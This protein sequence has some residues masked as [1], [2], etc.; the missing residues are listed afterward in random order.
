MAFR[1]TGFSITNP[2]SPEN[3]LS[4]SERI[5]IAF[6]VVLVALFVIVMGLYFVRRH[7]RY[8]N[9]APRNSKTSAIT[10][11]SQLTKCHTRDERDNLGIDMQVL[12]EQTKT[13]G[14]PGFNRQEGNQQHHHDDDD[15]DDDGLQLLTS[16]KEGGG[17]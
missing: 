16:S 17:G 13:A 5:A 1:C 15:D 8:R 3:S 2:Q 12:A 14:D 4:S 9:L 11:H 6:A 7:R 10:E